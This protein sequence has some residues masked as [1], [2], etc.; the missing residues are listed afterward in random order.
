[1]VVLHFQASR[2]TE[3]RSTAGDSLPH[4]PQ[5]SVVLGLLAHSLHP[6]AVTMGGGVKEVPFYTRRLHQWFLLFLPV[7]E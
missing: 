4:G 6:V 2:Q 1:M 5:A 7:A 3:F